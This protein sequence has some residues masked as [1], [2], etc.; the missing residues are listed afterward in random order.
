MATI[1]S[2]NKKYIY[3][4]KYKRHNF[5][6]RNALIEKICKGFPWLLCIKIEYITFCLHHAKIKSVY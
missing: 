1:F 2:M 5:F 6:L 4:Y 3:K